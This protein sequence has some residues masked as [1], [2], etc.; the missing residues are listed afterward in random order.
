MGQIT[1]RKDIFEASVLK[2]GDQ[3]LLCTNADH[4]GREAELISEL[5]NHFPGVEFTIVAGIT[6]LLVV[7]L[8]PDAPTPVAGRENGPQDRLKRLRGQS[9]G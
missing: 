8:D 3:V 6:G 4:L 5:R 2:P 9:D 1:V 7:P